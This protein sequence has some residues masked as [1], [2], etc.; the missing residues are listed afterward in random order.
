MVGNFL[1]NP[2]R[3]ESL[4]SADAERFRQGSEGN[5]FKPIGALS[6]ISRFFV[7]LTSEAGRDIL[8]NIESILCSE[9]SN[10]CG[11]LLSSIRGERLTFLLSHFPSPTRIPSS[12]CP[13]M[14]SRQRS[15]IR[16]GRGAFTIIELM[17][18]LGIVAILVALLIPAVQ[19]VRESARRS[20]CA[21]NLKQIGIAIAAYESA[22]GMFP[23]G[24]AWNASMHV[25]LLPFVDQGSL[26]NRYN[27]SNRTT[28]LGNNHEIA[29][30]KIPLYLCPTDAVP[31]AWP[32][33]EAAGKISTSYA[34]NS[35][36]GV[37]KHGYNGMFR[38]LAFAQP[39]GRGGPIRAVDVRR[40]LSNTAA[41]SEMLH[42]DGTH[43]RLRVNWNTPEQ[44]NDPTQY[45]QFAAYCAAIPPVPTE[46]GWRGNPHM[47][48]C[49]WIDGNIGSTMYNHILGPNQPS[50]LNGTAAQTAIVSAGSAH[51]GGVNLVYGDGHVAFI[52]DSIDIAVWRSTGARVESDLVRSN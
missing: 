21:A 48:G 51:R 11:T 35:G 25:C 9:I 22:H 49:P 30:T 5:Y 17:V 28:I 18:S 41:V 37:L 29:T 47:R 10:V 46:Y 27:F 13:S 38:Y 34:G 44:F 6:E 32:I 26:Y 7:S 52:G 12:L 16:D 1:A 39:P 42:A 20:Q 8:P 23:P 50:C 15:H 2:C 3:V 4:T 19:S 14:T 40:G 43:V 45:D 36:T 33:G 31:A 24:G